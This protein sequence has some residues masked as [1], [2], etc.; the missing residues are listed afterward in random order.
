MH[1]WLPAQP[2][3]HV[4]RPVQ[5][6]SS[7]QTRLDSQQLA[8]MQGE[9]VT[10][11]VLTETLPQPATD[12]PDA[13][14]LAPPASPPGPEPDPPPVTAF[15]QPE[16]PTGVQPPSAA[17]RG[18]SEEHASQPTITIDAQRADAAPAR[19]FPMP[20]TP[21]VCDGAPRTSASWLCRQA[22]VEPLGGPQELLEV[23]VERL[24]GGHG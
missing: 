8:T 5:A 3:V 24:P 14:S 4:T 20:F 15:E 18:L 12:S 6:A 9:H 23:C 16:S 1:D 19:S 11:P 21:A 10:F 7:E 22:H 17:G 2:C 13:P